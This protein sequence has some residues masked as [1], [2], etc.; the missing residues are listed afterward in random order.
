MPRLTVTGEVLTLSPMLTSAP[1]FLVA[2]SHLDAA[3][4][5]LNASEALTQSP[6]S[7]SAP[8]SLAVS[9]HLDAALPRLSASANL[10]RAMPAA[11]HVLVLANGLSSCQLDLEARPFPPYA[12][13]WRNLFCAPVRNQGAGFPPEPFLV[14]RLTVT[15][16]VLALSPML[17]SAPLFLV[18]SPHLD[19]AFPQ[20]SKV[21][22]IFQPGSI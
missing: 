3:F 21:I 14:P 18:A 12:I 2:S 1:L 7:T 17:T 6:M 22:H 15:N 4:P 11:V 9:F 10:C 19:A 16:E 8:P 20:L 13:L 5:R